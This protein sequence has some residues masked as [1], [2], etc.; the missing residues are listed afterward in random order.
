M[1]HPD[2]APVE[3]DV[4][5]VASDYAAHLELTLRVVREI[6]AR[7]MTPVVFT[8]RKEARFD[9]PDLRITFGRRVADFLVDVAR[10]LPSSTSYLVTKGGITSSDV[11]SRALALRASRVLGQISKGCSV[12]QCPASHPRFPNLPVVIFPGNVGGPNGLIDVLRQF[13]GH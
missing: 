1:A 13:H 7:G 6:H 5:K 3:V 2:V 8:T 4:Q 9:T 11:L 12:V 10:T